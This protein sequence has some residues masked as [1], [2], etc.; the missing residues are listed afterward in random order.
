MKI[1]CLLL[2]TCISIICLFLSSIAFSDEPANQEK[3]QAQASYVIGAGDIL[4]ITTWKEEDFS[5]EE[6]LVRLDGK[7]SFPLLDDIQAAGLPCWVQMIAFCCKNYE[8]ISKRTEK[9]SSWVIGILRK[10]L[11]DFIRFKDAIV[12]VL[13]NNNSIWLSIMKNLSRNEKEKILSRIFWDEDIKFNELNEMIEKKLDE[14]ASLKEIQ[15]YR[16]LLTSCDW[17][18]LIKLVPPTKIKAILSDSIIE[19]IYPKELKSRYRYAR[20]VLSR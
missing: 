19:R 9:T 10:Q 8:R 3:D 5:L 17:Y 4:S 1:R 18:T 15:F 6:V 20:D 11:T 13:K 16:R 12:E 2:V 7:I 14:T